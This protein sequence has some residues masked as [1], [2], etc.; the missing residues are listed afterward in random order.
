M[1]GTK[2][3]MIQKQLSENF[4]QVFYPKV[5]KEPLLNPPA[6]DDRAMKRF[7]QSWLD[8]RIKSGNKKPFYAQFYY[9]N[10]HYPFF[11]NKNRNSTA[12]RADGML[13]SVDESIE[14]IFTALNGTENLENTMVLGSGDHGENFLDNE[15]KYLRVE[16]WNKN[17]FHVPVY[18]HMPKNVLNRTITNEK[19]DNLRHNTHQLTSILDIFPTVMHV[20]EGGS[21][22]SHE[23][24]SESH[25]LRGLDLL[26]NRVNSSR[27]AW[28]WPGTNKDF[29]T[30]PEGTM[31]LHKGTSSSLHRR[32][33]RVPNQNI[34]VVEK[35]A[36]IVE[37]KSVKSKEEQKV[38]DM[39][40]WKEIVKSL[41]STDDGA[42]LRRKAAYSSEFLRV[43]NLTVPEEE[44][45]V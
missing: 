15:G 3:F 1:E 29:K 17:I 16:F 4:D 14:M 10:A 5:T 25:C 40:E 20:L 6:Q 12:S 32:F 41:L 27:V 45:R 43:L 44:K 38:F 7:F 36:D 24:A 13:Q 28:S 31:A 18:M 30:R 26:E 21:R 9:F 8:K 39:N 22:N 11:D 19:Y 42:L 37:S 34:F 33:G 2:W 35:Y 23:P